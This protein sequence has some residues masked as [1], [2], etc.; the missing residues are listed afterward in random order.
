MDRL[1]AVLE[2]ICDPVASSNLDA[3]ATRERVWTYGELLARSAA[4]QTLL[5]GDRDTVVGLLLPKGPDLY[6]SMIA[7]A[8]SGITYCPLDAESPEL[9]IQSQLQAAG[10]STVIAPSILRWMQADGRRTI[11]LQSLNAQEWHAVPRISTK[12]SKWLY[13]ITTSGST[14]EPKVIAISREAVANLLDWSR[15]FLTLNSHDRVSQFSN[16]FFDLS[17]LEIWGALA[18]KA[19]LVPLVVQGDRLRPARVMVRERISVWISVPTAVDLMASD[20]TVDPTT[21]HHLR[22]FV[23]CGEPLKRHHVRWL[24]EN[25]H[26]AR[27]VNT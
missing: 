16:P 6:A 1:I 11:S 9:A 4:I 13:R 27:V 8:A 24:M 3:L 25:T 15:Q 26:T 17:V 2:S 18:A 12:P 10:V 14:G 23:F 7:C 19:C 20:P 5:D 21:L 22:L